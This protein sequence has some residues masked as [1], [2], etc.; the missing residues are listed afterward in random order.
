MSE[1]GREYPLD[2]IER[3]IEGS[4]DP[5]VLVLHGWGG[6]YRAL[7]V[8]ATPISQQRNVIS[9]SLPGFGDSPEPPEAW[10][11]WEYVEVIK[12]WLEHEGYR[13]VDVIAHSFGGRIAIGLAV[14]YPDFIVRL[15]LIDSAGLRARRSFKTRLKVM[16]AR[17]LRRF[18]QIMQGRTAEFLNKWRDQLG[19]Q[20]WKLASPVMRSILVKVL[21]EDLSDELPR[22]TAPALLIFGEIDTATPLWMAQKMNELIPDSKLEVIPGVGHFCY[23]EKKGEVLSRVWRH[24]DLPTAW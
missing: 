12:T 18:A 24:L 4:G 17:N 2:K 14:R 3:G 11:T 9:L 15:I 8:I 22:I 23:L 19:S 5:P 16:T 13:K 7:S 1:S 20:D 6:D 10:G 21:D